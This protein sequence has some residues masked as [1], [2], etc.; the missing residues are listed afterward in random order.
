MFETLDGRELQLTDGPDEL[1]VASGG[2]ARRLYGDLAELHA[3]R[4][5]RVGGSVY[6]RRGSPY[7]QIK[8]LVDG[9]WRQETTHT[10]SKRD[11]RALLREKVF[12]ASAGTLPGTAS[13]EQIIDAL[14]DDAR[15][16]GRKF[17]RL[18]GAARALKA[19]LEG[20]RAEDC[21]YAVWLKYAKERQ[22][23]AAADTVH[24]ELTIAKRAYKVARANR[25][26]SRIPDFPPVGN[27]RVRQGF[28][29]PR[30]WAQFGHKAA[31]RLSRCGRLRVSLWRARDGNL[32]AQVGRH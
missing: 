13:F 9:K 12:H 19:R 32:V 2:A 21:N 5:K 26:V 28:M 29:D 8:Y 18:A 20:Y 6:P 4:L 3:L 24:L 30:Q 15:V 14:V 1:Y 23:E 31:I 27:L 7:W 10:K 17:A 11:A 16:R 22:Q 25:L